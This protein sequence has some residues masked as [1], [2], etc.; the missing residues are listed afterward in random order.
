LEKSRTEILSHGW[1]WLAMAA[2]LLWVPTQQ[3]KSDP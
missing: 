3:E 1:P 2:A